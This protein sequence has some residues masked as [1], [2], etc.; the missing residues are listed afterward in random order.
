MSRFPFRW[1]AYRG[2]EGLPLGIVASNA[3]VYLFEAFNPGLTASLQ[4]YFPALRAGEYWRLLTFLFV[5]PPSGPFF[6]L[7]W[8][9]MVY[10]FASSL[11]R[12]W[13]SFRFTL[14]YLLTAACTAAVGFYP[15]LEP[16]T[17]TYLNTALFLAF[18]ALYPEM[19]VLLFFVLPVR[20]K[21]IGAVTW[22]WMAWD[23]F[24]GGAVT[25]WSVAAAVF[26]YLCFLGPDLWERLRLRWQVFR[27]RR[28]W[29]D[30]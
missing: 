22:G 28:R 1:G 19:E 18:A 29:E 5:P 2:I 30:R 12:A 26:S 6:L 7:L 24:R 11:E 15:A 27:N 4:L 17:N 16:V 10:L 8:L 23:F 20:V 14:F 25:R 21:Y 3:L 13:G 9:Y